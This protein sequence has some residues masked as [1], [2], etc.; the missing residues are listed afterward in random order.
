MVDPASIRA[1]TAELEAR[2]GLLGDAVVDAAIAALAAQLA[3][4]PAADAPAPTQARLRQ[5][6][7]LFA[8]VA[9]STAWMQALGAEEAAE[10][11]DTLL[12]RMAAVVR[13]A[14]GEVLRFTG[15]GLKAAFGTHGLHEDEAERAVRAGLQIL[16]AAS[17]LLRP[18]GAGLATTE[19]AGIRVGVHTGP[20]LMGAGHEA[21]RTAMGHAVHL[22]ARMEQSAPVG[23]LRISHETWL[24]V[25][26][27]FECEAQAPLPVKGVQAPL[28][29]WL[30][31]G[32]A[33]NPERASLRG[34]EGLATPLV[35]REQ[36]LA[37]LQALAALCAR[38][39]RPTLALVSAEAGIGKTRLR[40]ELLHRLGWPV[41][42][43]R[44]HPSAALQPYGLWRQL[45]TRWLEIGDEQPAAQAQ[46]RFVQGL[47][48]WL[49]ALADAAAAARRLGHLLGL[50][51]GGH[52]S[53]QALGGREL[54]DA[55]VT[56]LAALLAARAAE[57]PLLLVLDDV[58]WADEASLDLLERLLAPAPAL[59][60]A[61]LAVLLLARP[62][63]AMRRAPPRAGAD[64]PAVELRLQPLTAEQGGT[65]ADALLAPVDAP[66]PELKE[67]LVSR[68]DG[69]PFYMEELLRMLMDDGVIDTSAEPWR[70]RAA[71]WSALR[72]P[73]TLVGVL[74]ARLDALPAD[75][76]AALQHASIIGPVFWDSALQRLDAQA[77]AALP[78]LQRKATIVAHDGS[79]FA[80]EREH[81]FH[82]PLLHEVTYGTV[83]KATRHRGHA[84][85]G[86]WLA[87]HLGERAGEFLALTAGHFE[88]AGDSAMALEYYDRARVDAIARFA[89]ED[90]LGLIER[91]L[92][93]PAL[94]A[95]PRWRFQVL[96]SRRSAL[97]RLGRQEAARV[98][99]Q[100]LERFAETCDNDA[101]RA[102]VATLR[103]LAA[104]HQGQPEEA[105][106][107]A[108]QALALSARHGGPE[109]AG[110]AALAHGELAW[111]ALMARDHAAAR[112]QLAQGMR[113]ARVAATV[114][115]RDGGYS[116]YDLQLHVLEIECEQQ[117]RRHAA[118]LAAADQALEAIA[119]K[120]RPFPHDRVM[121]LQHRSYALRLLGRL[122]EAAA[123]SAE[124]MVIAEQLS[125]PRLVANACT[126][127]APVALARGDLAQ[128][129]ALI[130]RLEHAAQR[131]DYRSVRPAIFRLRAEL[132]A[133]R[134]DEVE[135][136]HWRDRAVDELRAAQREPEAVQLR[137]ETALLD[138]AR[139]HE[140][141]ALGAV[142][143]ALA[144]AEAHA[145]P[146]RGLLSPRAL[147]VCHTL[148]A[149]RGDARAAGVLADLR[150]QF[151]AQRADAPD[152]QALEALLGVPHWRETAA[153]LAGP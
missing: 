75:E 94:D 150:L 85:A 56:A 28:Q 55:A 44:A 132:A 52:P 76:L 22:A 48:P 129:Q 114:P 53:V 141:D 21:D 59:A 122:E 96:V 63:L 36:P 27:L 11:L 64:V 102:D 88:R 97:D 77:P 91:T 140:D 142:E 29:T 34:I 107:L 120:S 119:R 112:Q 147:L 37:A 78:A 50:D 126:H 60:N 83:L 18:P 104:D 130:D 80:N 13:E 57:G 30:V 8:D 111:L 101:M 121:L 95:H 123:A 58:H 47:Q 61:P 66:P 3:P 133:A 23:R 139:G 26:G 35:G 65:L 151:E 110:S 113:H 82:H 109:A 71:Q 72:V 108:H 31:T 70:V 74:Q 73:G 115:G 124:A 105:R 25:R 42:Q 148:L 128:A 40:R 79:R 131:A 86:R 93:Q 67:L 10:W 92:A 116:G 143:A 15:D 137:C 152:A 49:G 134:Q 89:N 20:V 41:L 153:R 125:M 24:Q 19:P 69:N 38:E 6:S 68:A 17:P 45:L 106:E 136:L 33:H 103:M 84:E 43:A 5:I 81:A 98:A 117:Q 14:G 39:R 4:A 12:Q 16:Q 32:V 138:A 54:R 99:L 9:G 2:R 1:A 127:A 144:A 118:C 145:D 146:H 87:E 46:E 135:A 100:E 62:E 7:V 90:A 149:Q 51:F